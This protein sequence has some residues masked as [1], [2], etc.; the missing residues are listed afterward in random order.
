MLQRFNFS[1]V[2]QFSSLRYAS[3]ANVILHRMQKM[4]LQNYYSTNKYLSF[5][6]L[7]QRPFFFFFF[8]VKLFFRCINILLVQFFVETF[9]A[10][11]IA[12]V[13]KHILRHL[14]PP[15]KFVRRLA[16]TIRYSHYFN[17]NNV[18]NSEKILYAFIFSTVKQIAGSS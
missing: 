9:C 11:K 3:K 5:F 16:K 13:Y 14:Y 18:E 12:L 1:R 17:G 7:H 10:G 2:K 4:I 15:T 8:F 6:S